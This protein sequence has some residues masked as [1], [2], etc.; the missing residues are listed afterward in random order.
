MTSRTYLIILEVYSLNGTLRILVLILSLFNSISISYFSAL[1][2]T[3][4]VCISLVAI[5][6]PSL[7]CEDD[8]TTLISTITVSVGPFTN[9]TR[10]IYLNVLSIFSQLFINSVNN[11]SL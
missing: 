9:D 10:F 1:L 11:G 7:F 8:F 3:L 4:E 5:N 2:N 6:E